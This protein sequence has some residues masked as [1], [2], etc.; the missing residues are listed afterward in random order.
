MCFRP[1]AIEMKKN[2]PKCGV[3]NAQSATVC[4]ECGTELPVGPPLPG[5]SGVPKVPAAPGMP[6]APGAPKVPGAP[7]AQRTETDVV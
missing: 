2:C 6:G 3:E 4:K 1:V 7:S 5:A